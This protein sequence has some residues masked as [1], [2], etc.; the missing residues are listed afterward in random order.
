MERGLKSGYVS[1]EKYAEALRLYQK[2]HEETRSAMRDEAL[3]Y[4]ANPSMYFDNS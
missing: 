2:Q 1:K 4:K 3:V